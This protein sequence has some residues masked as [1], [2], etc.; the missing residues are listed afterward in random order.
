MAY[1]YEAMKKAKNWHHDIKKIGAD[2]IETIVQRYQRSK[3]P[4]LLDSIIK[5]Y[6]IFRP[7]WARA[8]APFFG[9]DVEEGSA[10]HDKVVWSS[11]EKFERKKTKKGDGFAF[12]AYLVSGLLNTLKNLYNQKTSHK[13]HPRKKCP[14]CGDL[15]YKIDEKHLSHRMTTEK[16]RKVHPKAPLSSPDGKTTCPVSGDRVDEV[17]EPYLNRL[18][19]AY[20]MEDFLA[21]FPDLSPKEVQCPMTGM[22]VAITPQ[23]PASLGGPGYGEK[24]FIRDFPS[25]EAIITCPF[26]GEKTLGM[27]QERLDAMFGQFSTKKRVSLRSFLLSNKHVTLKARRTKVR[28][29]YTGKMVDQ[30]TPQMLAEAGTNV[31]EHL[32]KYAKMWIDKPYPDTVC[33]P[34]T[35][36]RVKQVRRS[37]LEKLDRTVIEFYNAVSEYP[38]FRYQVRCEECEKW[39]DNIWE[40]LE[41]TPHFYAESMTLQEYEASFGQNATQA[42]VS[43]NSYVENESGDSIHVADLFAK[44]AKKPIDMMEVEDSLSKVANDEMDKRIVAAIRHSSTVEDVFFSAAE[45]RIMPLRFKFALGMTK[46]VRMAIKASVGFSDF[47]IAKPPNIGAKEVVVMVP[48]RSSLR[49]RLMRMID[50]S[51]IMD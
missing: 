6:A 37:D 12:N 42:Y 18:L 24:E 20:S 48:S 50:E 1:D 5:N 28:N 16:Y 14:I 15:V 8:F 25:C 21:E 9:D 11:A 4:G 40:H 39:V 31:K 22:M 19:G 26:S 29:P 36:R 47:D 51:D 30:L 10:V 35:G 7:G 23:Y 33:C 45:K 17:T 44:V 49:A 43:N 27:T 2:W 3:D 46:E 32:A 34:F 13:N 41:A 38:L